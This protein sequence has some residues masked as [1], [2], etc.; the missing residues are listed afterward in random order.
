M[1]KLE[2]AN[3][4]NEELRKQ[5]KTSAVSMEQASLGFEKN[6]NSLQA[7]VLSILLFLI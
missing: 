6:Y 2:E 3:R 7:R 5:A 4:A 1:K